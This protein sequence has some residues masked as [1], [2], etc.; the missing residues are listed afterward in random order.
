MNF[1]KRQIIDLSVFTALFFAL[2]R[3]RYADDG[4]PPV[5]VCATFTTP[6]VNA[7]GKDVYRIGTAR[8][9][10]NSPTNSYFPRYRTIPGGPGVKWVHIFSHDI[11][12]RQRGGTVLPEKVF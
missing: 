6:L 12:I 5:P 3:E 11:K 7:G 2:I 1:R 4:L 10:P 9:C 8:H